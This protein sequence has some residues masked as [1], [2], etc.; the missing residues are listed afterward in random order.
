[1]TEHMKI[2]QKSYYKLCGYG[3]IG[4][5]LMQHPQ[6]TGFLIPFITNIILHIYANQ[7]DN[8]T[9]NTQNTIKQQWRNQVSSALQ[10]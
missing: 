7:Q 2:W 8:I 9:E 1:M 10:I 4:P 5:L 3:N 6:Y